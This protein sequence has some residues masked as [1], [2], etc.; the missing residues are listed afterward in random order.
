MNSEI[1]WKNEKI[2]RNSFNSHKQEEII[3]IPGKDSTNILPQYFPLKSFPG[4]IYKFPLKSS[5]TSSKSSQSQ[6]QQ[7]AKKKRLDNC[8]LELIASET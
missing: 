5:S 2:S 4:V 6:N 8:S 3:K 7:I 1:P